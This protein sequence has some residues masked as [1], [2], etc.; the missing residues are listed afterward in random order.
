MT[1]SAILA[2]FLTLAGCG[3]FPRDSEDTLERAKRGEPLTV[4]Y[5]LA[6]PW[7]RAGANGPGGLEADLVRAWA[8]ETRVPLQWVE[9]GE[10]QLVDGLHG[11]T[12]DLVVGG[13]TAKT[14]HG[15]KVGMTQPYFTAE[16]VVGTVPGVPKPESLDKLDIRYDRRRP[17]FAAAIRGAGGNPIPADPGALR[18]IAAVYAP[19]LG[20]LGLEN[21]G[22]RLLKEKRVIA[23]APGENALALSLDKFLHAHRSEIEAR[24][25]AEAGR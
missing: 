3:D 10:S 2:L 1:R 25:G 20:R 8:A 23:T 4:G 24:L 11:G 6:E 14:P 13:F 22:K 5:S 18:P 7:V 19:E 15:P 9:G 21:S 16:L 17:E 12:L